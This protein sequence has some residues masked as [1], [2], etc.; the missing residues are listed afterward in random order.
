MLKS[1]SIIGYFGM[2]GGLIVLQREVGLNEYM[3][4]GTRLDARVS[5]ELM[6]SVFEPHSLIHDGALVIDALPAQAEEFPASHP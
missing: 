1:L 2:I 6:E 4:I 3:E 5:R